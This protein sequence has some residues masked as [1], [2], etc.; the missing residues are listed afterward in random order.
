MNHIQILKELE[1]CEEA[2]EWARG[3][4]SVEHAWNEC[5]RSDWMLWLDCNMDLFNDQ[6]RRLMACRFVRET[7]I[8]EGKT[9]LDLLTDE[10][11]RNAVIVA[12]RFANG[13]A[14]QEELDAAWAA[15]RD[16]VTAAAWDA[17]WDA[18]RAAA[19]DAVTAAAWDA[20]W[21][22]AWAAARDA[23][24]AA[25]WAAAWAAARDAARDAATAVQSDIIRSYGNP[26]NENNK[27]GE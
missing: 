13:E 10:R 17:A 5:K 15:S 7:P 18:A 25:A 24:T 2:V 1:A 22:A 11:S 20:A 21:A 4:D 16:A 19:R 27:K 23:V 8:G 6:Q 12:E 9:V 3:Y 14:T 26:F